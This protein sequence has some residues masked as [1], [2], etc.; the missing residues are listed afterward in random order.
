MTIFF[1]ATPLLSSIASG[2]RRRALGVVAE[3]RAGNAQQRV[4]HVELVCP[5]DRLRR[6]RCPGGRRHDTKQ[7]YAQKSDRDVRSLCTR[8]LALVLPFRPYGGDAPNYRS[9]CGEV[10]SGANI[11][12]ADGSKCWFPC[13]APGA[14]RSACPSYRLG[15]EGIPSPL[16]VGRHSD[17]RGRERSRPF[18]TVRGCSLPATSRLVRSYFP[19]GERSRPFATGR[20]RSRLFAPHLYRR[21]GVQ[22]SRARPDIFHRSRSRPCGNRAL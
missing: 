14:L 22:R 7:L 19:R 15:R 5:L 12:A 10:R 9:A 18:A 11:A 21:C 4:F 16:Q 17:P 20:D 3:Q 2:V 1:S 6:L 13:R 8:D